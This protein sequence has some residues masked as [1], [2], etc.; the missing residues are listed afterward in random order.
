M[1]IRL[2]IDRIIAADPELTMYKLH[3]LTGIRPNTI[4]DLVN[5]RAKHWSVENLEKIMNALKLE[6][7]SELMEFVKDDKEAIK[8]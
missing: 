7:V 3:V 8:N 2:K 1:L 5:N 6:D 4:S